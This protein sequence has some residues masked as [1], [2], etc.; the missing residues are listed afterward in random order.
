LHWGNRG[1]TGSR[2]ATAQCAWL[3]ALFGLIGAPSAVHGQSCPPPA[4]SI[5]APALATVA[6]IGTGESFVL[7]VID[8]VLVDE[9]VQIAAG[10]CFQ[11]VVVANVVT[12]NG[13]YN[14]GWSWHL[15]EQSLSLWDYTVEVCDASPSYVEQNLADWAGSTYCPWGGWIIA[16]QPAAFLPEDITQDGAV[17]A[18]DLDRI[19]ACLAAPD[20]F[21]WDVGSGCCAADIDG[22]RIVNC[23]D[24][25]LLEAA[26]TDTS[27]PV[28]PLACRDVPAISTL[29]LG[30]LAGILVLGAVNALRARRA[31]QSSV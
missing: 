24:W 25:T 30:L 16:V 22:S 13:G 15:D 1:P 6:F 4:Q 2:S 23:A 10:Q 3:V 31:F 29:G 21:C 18:T 28:P 8:Q 9:M 19:T 12:G 20:A 17:D 11:K 7:H 27:P 26:W 5:P 14:A